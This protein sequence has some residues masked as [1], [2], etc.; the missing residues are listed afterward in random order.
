MK[1]KIAIIGGRNLMEMDIVKK[2][3]LR[4]ILTP[5]GKVNYFLFRDFILLC[6]HGPKRNI[7]PHKINH[8]A[9]IFALKKLGVKFIFSFNSVGSLKNN[10]KPGQILIPDDYINFDPPT[11][12]DNELRHITP[13]FSLKLRETL[14]KILKKLKLKFL[15]KGVYFNFKGPRL[16]T[17]AE[18]RM[19]KKFADVTGMTM[20][21]E[22]TLAKELNLEYV[23][24]CSVDNFAHGIIKKLLTQKE[25]EEKQKK[26]AKLIEK[27]I[28]EILKYGPLN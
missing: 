14:I 23:S 20:A 17:K 18:I 16:E 11:F 28:K 8:K 12:Y 5:F 25:I 9:N 2:A 13:G 3:K 19:I 24:L 1:N 4:K 27:I 15:K 10:I 26:S 7:P 6:R 22:A 21:G